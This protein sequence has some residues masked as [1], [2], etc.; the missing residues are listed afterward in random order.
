MPTDA[1]RAGKRGLAGTARALAGCAL[2]ALAGC[3]SSGLGLSPGPSPDVAAAP[4]PDVQSQ[5][6]AGPTVGEAVG[7]GPVRVG[8]I[9]P[10]TQN[11]QPSSIGVSNMPGAMVMTRIPKRANSRAIGRVMA[12]MPPFEAAYAAWPI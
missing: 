6:L 5:P 9:L 8:L 11:G 7:A 2:L 3:T 1:L 4:V 12:T 10:L